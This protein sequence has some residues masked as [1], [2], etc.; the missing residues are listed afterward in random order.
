MG[1]LPVL[2]LPDLDRMADDPDLLDLDRMAD[3]P[4]LPDLGQ[5][6]DDPDLL[7]L[8]PM[9]RMVDVVPKLAVVDQKAGEVPK[10]D[11]DQMAD[12]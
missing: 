5:T 10:M 6:V 4:D 12:R 3:D 7:D 2:D 9:V 11:P 1:D 8:D